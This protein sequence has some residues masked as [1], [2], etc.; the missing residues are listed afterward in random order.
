[1][2]QKVVINAKIFTGETEIA[3]GY[4]R[5]QDKII[6]TGSM[7]GFQEQSDEEVINAK[8]KIIIPGMID[9]HIHGGYGVDVM[10]ADPEKLAFL[11]DKLLDEGVTSFFA[12]TITQD[13]PAIEK[14]L[15]A[16]KAAKESGNT[17]IEGVHLEGPFISEKRAGAQPL[18]FIKAPDIDLFLKWHEASGNL[19]KLV[20]YAPEKERAREFEKVMMERGIVPSMGHSDA[21]REELLQS[22]TTHATHMYNGMRGLHHREA[23]V[24]GHALLSP[25]IQVE[26]I[27]DGIHV[28]PD[29]VNLTYKV[30]GASGMV[31]ISDAMRAKG[32]PDGV[33]ELGGQ[34]VYVKNGEA[35]LENGSLAGSILKMDQAFRNIIQ[36]T[37][38]SI[39]DAVQ[40]TS[41]N[42]AKEFGLTSKGT[43]TTGKDADFVIMDESLHVCETYSLGRKHQRGE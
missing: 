19:I 29:M 25:Q 31:L 18:E 1:M 36:F 14:A 12:T 3:N 17:I 41:V 24:A 33:S 23:G 43:L 4:I 9:V 5:F 22:K 26:M 10:D 13:Y 2:V 28:H 6:E 37:G 39:R 35:R 8:G 32:M 34:K 38:C 42:Q 7:D 16:V 27:A 21:V 11:S 30:K 20:T 40:M 15:R